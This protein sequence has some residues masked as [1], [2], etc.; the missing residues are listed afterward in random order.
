MEVDLD[1]VL[2]SWCINQAFFWVKY[3]LFFRIMY[4][5]KD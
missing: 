3:V 4:D 2:E 5:I 1:M